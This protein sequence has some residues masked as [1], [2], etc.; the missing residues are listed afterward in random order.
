MKKIEVGSFVNPKVIPQMA[1]TKQLL[2]KLDLNSSMTYSVLVPNKKY[3]EEALKSK[4]KEIAIFTAASNKFTKKNI[5]CTIEES[6]KKIKEFVPQAIKKGI[7]VRGYVSC[8]LG[9]PYEGVVDPMVVR[10]VSKRLFEVGCYEV[11]LGDTIGIGNPESTLKLLQTID[12][13]DGKYAFHFHDTG[14]KAISNI[15]TCLNHGY[16]TF[17]SS[18]GGLGGCPYAKKRVGNVA[19]ELVVEVMEHTKI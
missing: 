10:E 3:Y 17:D 15:L 12:K 6:F 2:K 1:D 18:I 8:V 19:T 4:V 13:D 16:D 9:C 11:S 7:K 5:N 14:G